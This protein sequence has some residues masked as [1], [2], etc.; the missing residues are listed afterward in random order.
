[1]INVLITVVLASLIILVLCVVFRWVKMPYFRVDKARII[2][3]LE[4]VL[5]G[6][7]TENDWRITLGMT[8]RHDPELE[9][10]RQ[11]CVDI[12]EQHFLEGS[13]T[14]YLF[15]KEGLEK[16]KVELETLTAMSE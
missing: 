12:E 11:R 7:A 15:T 16:I 9:L 14:G 6:Q 2:Q 8:I 5:T 10:F 1:M 4:M 3:V 13:T